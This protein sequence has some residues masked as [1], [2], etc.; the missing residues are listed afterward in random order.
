M[1]RS[2]AALSLLL[3][4]T[5]AFAQERPRRGG[6]G[7]ETPAWDVNAPPG[8]RTASAIKQRGH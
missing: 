6:G 3:V 2:F 5:T 8:A 1:I 4:S 7:S